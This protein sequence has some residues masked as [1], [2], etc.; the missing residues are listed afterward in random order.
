MTVSFLT[1]QVIGSPLTV[2]PQAQAVTATWAKRTY[3]QNY[4]SCCGLLLTGCLSVFI[5]TGCQN[6]DN[7]SKSSQP[8]AS[9]T[10]A[11]N[12]PVNTSHPNVASG[13]T[14]ASAPSSTN[15]LTLYTS[16]PKAQLQP[17]LTAYQQ[18][19]ELTIQVVN[20]EPMS[21]LA[22]LKAEGENSPADLIL[23]ED[24]GVFHHAVETNLLQPFSSDAAVAQVPER[25]RD[26]DGNWL[27]MSYYARTAVYDSRVLHKNDIS[28][29]ASFAKPT[30]FQKLCISQASYVPN[31]S[32][33]VNLINNLGVS[34]VQ[35]ALTGWVANLAMPPVLND[36][37]LLQAIESGKCQVGLVNSHSYM[38]YVQEHPDTPLKLTWSNKGYGGVH[39]NITGVAIP[40]TA[41]NPQLALAFIEWLAQKEQQTLYAS[42]SN[43][44]PINSSAESSVGLK[45]LG[46]IE[47]NPMPVKYYAERQKLAIEVMKDAGYP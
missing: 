25:Y 32:L 23:T 29:Y 39:T 34:R 5:L 9:A 19:N 16:V 2:L 28:S 37:A 11:Q 6:S 43:T 30:W 36:K 17:L 8:T 12:N 15:V 10:N 3:P 24:V 1:R 20:D 21:I 27:A 26:P 45:A 4:R 33:V 7:T 13:V 40:K 22:R 42:Y 38:N 31:Q 41:K 46:D 18:A 35:E 44:F 47:I 14:T